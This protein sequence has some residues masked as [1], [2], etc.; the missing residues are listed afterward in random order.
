MNAMYDQP[1]CLGDYL[2]RHF[3]CSCGREHYA[4]LKHVS[5]RKGALEDLPVFAKELGGAC[6]SSATRSPTA[7]P[8][9][10]AWSCSPPPG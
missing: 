7:S 10:G 9:S 8:G 6:T 3:T 5:V 4:P 1:H 2:D